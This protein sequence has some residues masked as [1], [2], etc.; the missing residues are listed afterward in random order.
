M[1]LNR[2]IPAVRRVETNTP[3]ED[4]RPATY[5]QTYPAL[6]MLAS[7]AA[8]D[9]SNRF[10]QLA[11]AV[12][13]WMPRVVRVDATKLDRAVAAFRQAAAATVI[14][15]SHVD[16]VATCLHSVVGAS[17]LLHFANPELFPIW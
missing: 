13:G 10:L 1:D 2:L 17:K 12:Y 5:L 15:E 4:S 16:D 14:N 9:D 8:T 11:A 6:L 7:S 3:A